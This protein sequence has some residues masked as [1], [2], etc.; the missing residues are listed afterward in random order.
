MKNLRRT[1]IFKYIN[2]LIYVVIIQFCTANAGFMNSQEEILSIKPVYDSFYSVFLNGIHL[3]MLDKNK[4]LNALKGID[5]T[6]FKSFKVIN[7]FDKNRPHFVIEDFA[8]AHLDVMSIIPI[9]HLGL[10][11]ISQD[12]S[13]LFFINGYFPLKAIPLFFTL[14]ESINVILIVSIASGINPFLGMVAE[15]FV[16]RR[17]NFDIILDDK[18][19]IVISDSKFEKYF[20]SITRH[21]EEQ[22]F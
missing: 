19:N 18:I 11:L 2:T 12:L 15:R 20:D 17:N 5:Y 7:V 21:L 6:N 9:A 22:T 14:R 1:S 10:L 3:G 16:L 4:I 13:N 8:K